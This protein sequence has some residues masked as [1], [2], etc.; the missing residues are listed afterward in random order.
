MEL[1]KVAK[2]CEL[3]YE[4]QDDIFRVYKMRQGKLKQMEKKF[5]K[6]GILCYLLSWEC[7]CV[8]KS[9]SVIKY[10][11]SRLMCYNRYFFLEN[12]SNFFKPETLFHFAK[13]ISHYKN[14]LNNVFPLQHFNLQ[15]ISFEEY[16]LRLH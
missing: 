4:E 3:M 1:R 8:G 9:M 5:S 12:Y 13:L 7:E 15:I 11:Y 6:T 16:P 2:C 10:V 14:K